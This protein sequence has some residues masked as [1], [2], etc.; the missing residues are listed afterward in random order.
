[1]EALTERIRNSSE[2]YGLVARVLH[3]SIGL[4]IVLQLALGFWTFEFMERDATRAANVGLHKALGVVLL[5]L[6]LARIGWRMYD[7]PPALPAAMSAQERTGARVGHILLYI[8]MLAMPILGILTSDT[9]GRP[10]DVFGL[11]TVP[12][13]LGE[14]EDLHELFEDLHKFG[15]YAL[16]LL[17]VFHLGAALMHRFIRRDGVAERM[18]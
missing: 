15:A 6:V 17:I 4:L 13:M 16:G 1:M 11:F 7:A 3:W 14:H 9:G 2:R 12:L 5:V 18:L 8:L 10:T